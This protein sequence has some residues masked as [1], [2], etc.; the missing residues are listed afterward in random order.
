[1]NRWDGSV[2]RPFPGLLLLLAI[3]AAGCAKEAPFE[4]PEIPAGDYRRIISLTPSVTEILYELGAGDR[5]K[6]VTRWC[7]YPPAAAALPRVGDFLL[8]NLEA[9]LALEPDLVILAP[10]GNL[11]R[12]GYNSLV[13]LG[14]PVLVVWNNTIEETLEAVRTIGTTIRL[15]REAGILAS[16]LKSDLE[17]EKARLAAVKPQEVLWLMGR[18]PLKAVGQGTFQHELLTAAGATNVTA[19]MGRWPAVTLEFVLKADPDV[20][21]DSSMD[22]AGKPGES[23]ATSL[24]E[25]FPTMKAVSSGRVVTL[26][27][28]CLYRPGPR[29]AEAM[30]LVARALAPELCEEK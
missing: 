2:S 14:L 17:S 24:W 20:I 11:L 21:I 1:M 3:A 19:D 7:D 5:V 26:H 8:P 16:R 23:S 27:H 22:S 4:P 9:I 29:M 6:G 13:E 30:R 28:D 25:S 18:H 12:G 10:T 15:D